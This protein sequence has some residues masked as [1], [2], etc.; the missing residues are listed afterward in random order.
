MVLWLKKSQRLSMNRFIQK[1]DFDGQVITVYERGL[2]A[3][4]HKGLKF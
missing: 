3:V 1:E 4:D 2:H